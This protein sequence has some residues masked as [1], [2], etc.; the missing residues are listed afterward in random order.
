MNIMMNRSTFLKKAAK[1]Y[2]FGTVLLNVNTD[3]TSLQNEDGSFSGDMWGEID[4]R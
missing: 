4:T 2:S 3:I 1:Y